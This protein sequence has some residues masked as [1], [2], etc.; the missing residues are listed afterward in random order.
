MGPFPS[1][2]DVFLALLLRPFWR[3]GVCG[4]REGRIQVR[5][6]TSLLKVPIVTYLLAAQRRIGILAEERRGG[7]R[8]PGRGL[9][10]YVSIDSRGCH[11]VREIDTLSLR[12]SRGEK[13]ADKCVNNGQRALMRGSPLA[14]S[15]DGAPNV[16]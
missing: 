4:R 14:T 16:A 15:A 9:L 3:D 8:T 2:L 11:R 7:A 6:R 5:L 10:T 13:I 12:H 1:P